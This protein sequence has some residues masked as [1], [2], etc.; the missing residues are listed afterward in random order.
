MF[1]T[2]LFLVIIC[3]LTHLQDSNSILSRIQFHLKCRIWMQKVIPDT[4]SAYRSGSSSGTGIH[5]YDEHGKLKQTCLYKKISIIFAK[6]NNIVQPPPPPAHFSLK[7]GR[8]LFS[9]PPH[10]TL[11]DS[12]AQLKIVSS[13]FLSKIHKLFSYVIVSNLLSHVLHFQNLLFMSFLRTP[14]QVLR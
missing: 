6:A 3:N 7:N 13:N 14:W 8:T 4:V 5:G 1:S 12:I 2:K 10:P 11:P 9:S